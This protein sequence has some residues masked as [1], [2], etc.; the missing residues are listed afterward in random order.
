MQNKE[1]KFSEILA[2]TRLN[3]E[4]FIYQCYRKIHGR[5]VDSS[6]LMHF[7][8][9]LSR[10]FSKTKII[11]EILAS[12]ESK[13]NI[14]NN[15]LARYYYANIASLA[16]VFNRFSRSQVTDPSSPESSSLHLNENLHELKTLIHE[17]LTKR[18]EK[19]F[20]KNA[21]SSP[22]HYAVRIRGGLGDALIVARLIRDLQDKMAEQATF[23]IYFHSPDVVRFV[24]ETVSGFNAIYHEDLFIGRLKKYGISIDCNQYVYFIEESI[25]WEYVSSNEVAG[26]IFHALYK[27]IKKSRKKIEPFIANLPYLDGAF[28]NHEVFKGHVRA[29]HLHYMSRLKYGGDR[30]DL[31]LPDI[32]SELHEKKYIVIHDGWD[33]AFKL[34][35]SRP[36]KAIPEKF[37]S[38]LV[39]HIRSK[40]QDI[41]IV[42]IGGDCGSD[43]KGV[44]FNYRSKIKFKESL[45]ILS[46]A[47]LHVDSES[48]LVH[49]ASALGVKA[50]VLFGPTNMQWFGYKQNINVAPPQCGNCWWSTEDWMDRCAA[51]HKTPVCTQHSAETI[52]QL[53][54]DELNPIEL[55]AAIS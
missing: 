52:S 10:G 30:F 9:R 13:A 7:T 31:S 54:L 2:L 29:Q 48:G 17:V 40:S 45:A 38:D 47:M 33:N 26:P 23:D 5:P 19:F 51:G 22:L 20:H 24:F 1:I 15:R 12:E 42:Q 53:I 55:T 50:V 11:K 39:V 46:R 25:D 28:A 49:F 43:I 21:P 44:D 16:S 34:E 18:E 41:L 3:N 14:N 36:V 6:G 8:N 37:W 32:P 4:D 35:T 27:S